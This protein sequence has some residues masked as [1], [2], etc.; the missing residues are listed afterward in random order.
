MSNKMK[1]LY[2]VAMIA[3]CLASNV[4]S[5]DT[6]WKV[7]QAAWTNPKPACVSP[8][9]LQEAESAYAQKNMAWFDKH[10]GACVILLSD[11]R[12]E[13]FSVLENAVGIKVRQDSSS[14]WIRL[15]TTHDGIWPCSPGFCN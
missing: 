8:D 3:V 4:A 5:A 14:S 11:L 6:N 7:G 2:S 13:V 10:R 15:Y 1:I 9:L 12:A